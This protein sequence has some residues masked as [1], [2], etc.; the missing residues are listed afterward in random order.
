M[1]NLDKLRA[2][3]FLEGLMLVV[4]VLTLRV[5]SLLLKLQGGP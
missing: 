2:L 4:S 5:V 1:S 3:T